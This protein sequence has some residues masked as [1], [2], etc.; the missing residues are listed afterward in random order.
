M[1][2]QHKR[3]VGTFPTFQQTEAALLQLKNSGFPMDHVSVIGNDV[4]QNSNLAGAKQGNNLKD[5]DNRADEG[6]TKGALSGATAGGLAGLLVGLGLIAIPGVGPVIMAGAAAT[7]LATTLTGGAIGTVAGG[8]LGGLVG[9]GIPKDRAKIF[10]DRVDQ[11]D[12]L[13]MIDEGTD[14]GITQVES[15]FRQHGIHEWSIYNSTGKTDS[16]IGN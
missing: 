7:A 3:A 9:L 8:L 2:G 11:G 10:S 14:E 6:A 12:Y 16:S 15:I 4:N 1:V 5:V 13:V